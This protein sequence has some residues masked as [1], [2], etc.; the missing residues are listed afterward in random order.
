[1]IESDLLIKKNY[2]SLVVKFRED[3]L[4][5]D[6]QLKQISDKSIQAK[7]SKKIKELDEYINKTLD[8]LKRLEKDEIDE[9]ENLEYLVHTVDTN[10]DNKIETKLSTYKINPNDA[11][12]TS[13]GLFDFNK[14]SEL[15]DS[16]KIKPDS[17]KIDVLSWQIKILV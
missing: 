1:M 4:A 9:G 5:L 6:K 8:E 2:E 16:G 14:L 17:V 11:R 10:K 7:L 15:V 12:I 3:R 13:N